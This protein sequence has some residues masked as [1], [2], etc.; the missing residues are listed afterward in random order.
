[1]GEGGGMET[2]E[3]GSGQKAEE[4]MKSVA[5]YLPQSLGDHTPSSMITGIMEEERSE[6]APP[7]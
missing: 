7:P 5:F 2:D 3:G 4:E 1:M 6:L